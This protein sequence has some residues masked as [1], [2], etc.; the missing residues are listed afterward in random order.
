MVRNATAKLVYRPTGVSELYDLTADPR[1]TRNLFAHSA[2]P[3]VV[4]LRQALLA[5]LLDWSVLT[6]DVTPSFTDGR[7]IPKS[8]YAVNPADPWATRLEQQREL[9][10]RHLEGDYLGINGVLEL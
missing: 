10:R 4:A 3:T 7:K 2:P 1:E 6:S 8:S 5:H 9:Q